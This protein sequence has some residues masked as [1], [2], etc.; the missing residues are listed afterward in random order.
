[1]CTHMMYMCMCVYV[2][3][4]ICEYVYVSAGA[5]EVQKTARDHVAGV[6]DVCES[7]S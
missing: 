3:M 4:N 2:H 7:V 5:C 6:T 1:M